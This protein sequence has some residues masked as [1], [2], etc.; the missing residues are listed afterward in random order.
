MS[1]IRAL[2]VDI[3]G[4][5]ALNNSGRPWFGE[6]YEKR[7]HEDDVNHTVQKVVE[8]LLFSANFADHVLFVSG[9]AE[10]GREA[11]TLWLAE[12]AGFVLDDNPIL[13]DPISLFMR[14]DKDF[15]SDV[16]VKTEI[17]NDH[18]RDVYDVRLALDDKP[19]L[20][21]LWRGLGIPAWQVNEYR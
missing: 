14:K 3:D 19:E 1:R 7:L 16:E 21:T 8:A 13:C 20:I 15:R 2:L 18:I 17:Y 10:V 12:K 11:T 9:R 4:T 6:G 5:L